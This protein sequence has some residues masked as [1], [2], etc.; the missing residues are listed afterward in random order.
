MPDSRPATVS[1]RLNDF[2]GQNQEAPPYPPTLVV[3]SSVPSLHV[4]TGKPYVFGP[5][6]VELFTAW[7][8]AQVAEAV[9]PG[10]ACRQAGSSRR[11]L[12][13]NDGK[14]PPHPAGGFGNRSPLTAF[15]H[16]GLSKLPR[17]VSVARVPYAP[18]HRIEHQDY[19]LCVLQKGLR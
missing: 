11:Q 8:F 3:H 15:N 19:S 4:L 9:S 1:I 16:T 14:E 13:L 17:S 10:S 18:A 6:I 12:T 2:R 7:V 5:L